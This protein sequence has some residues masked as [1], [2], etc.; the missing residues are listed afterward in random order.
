[1]A[2]ATTVGD[3]RDSAKDLGPA[4]QE[5]FETGWYYLSNGMFTE[6]TL[7]QAGFTVVLVLILLKQVM[8]FIADRS[9]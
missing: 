5:W 9:Q 8:V 7:G 3:V 6:L 1:M 2:E 4:V